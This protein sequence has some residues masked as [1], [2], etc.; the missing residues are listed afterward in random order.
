[1]PKAQ[2][3]AKKQRG[4]EDK[5]Q[6]RT[7]SASEAACITLQSRRERSVAKNPPRKTLSI[8]FSRE[9]ALEA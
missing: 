6:N 8:S 5:H 1:M 9:R 4:P 2:V 7:F 3:E